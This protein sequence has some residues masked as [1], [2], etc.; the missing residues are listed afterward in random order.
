[1]IRR[2][3][4]IVLLEKQKYI[5]DCFQSDPTFPKGRSSDEL[6]RAEWLGHTKS[7]VFECVAEV[8]EKT[9][10][11]GSP[12]SIKRSYL[13]VERQMKVSSQ[14]WRYNQLD[15]LFLQMLGLESDLGYGDRAKMMAWRSHR[16]KLKARKRPP[17]SCFTGNISR[18]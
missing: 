5:R 7:R 10:A 18:P 12:E 13:Q 4:V 14:A 2:N 8:L 3:E 11:F 9:D 15:H 16:P 1:M 6:E 17:D